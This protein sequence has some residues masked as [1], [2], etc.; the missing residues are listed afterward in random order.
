MSPI[1]TI[2]N[3]IYCFMPDHLH[4]IAMGQSDQSDVLQAIGRFKQTSGYCMRKQN[5]EFSWQKGFHDRVIRER[6]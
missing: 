2:F 1:C 6:E 5:S 4:V 3:A